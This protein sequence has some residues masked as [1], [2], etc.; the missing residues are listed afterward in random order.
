MMVPMIE[1]SLLPL[2]ALSFWLM[3]RRNMASALV[4]VRVRSNRN[5][6]DRLGR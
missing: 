4:P 1:M 3:L 6:S 5:R 2:L